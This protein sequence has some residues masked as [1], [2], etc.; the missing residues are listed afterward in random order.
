MVEPTLFFCSPVYVISAPEYIN[1]TKKVSLEYI[2][3]KHQEQELNE[4]YPIFQTENYHHDERL[5]D[6]TKIIL[7]V[8]RNILNEQGYDIDNFDLFFSEFWCQE[9]LKASGHDRHVHGNGSVLSGFYFFEDFEKSCRI[10]FHDPRPAKEFGIYLPERKKDNA[11]LASDRIVMIPQKG[12]L[13]L[14][15][16]W[17]PHSILRNEADQPFRFI[18]FNIYASL[19]M[20]LVNKK[21]TII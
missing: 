6:F 7:S 14:T 10:E 17:L 21:V 13:V 9:H 20:E 8:S 5:N 11:T 2:D 4:C 19:N 16:S 3:K 12:N 1:I 18:H 15:N